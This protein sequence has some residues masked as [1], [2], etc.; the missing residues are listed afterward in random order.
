MR[1]KT[2]GGNYLS[3]SRCLTEIRRSV[4]LSIVPSPRLRKYI[5]YTSLGRLGS[6]N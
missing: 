2:F 6:G 3:P 5:K 1:R 4:S